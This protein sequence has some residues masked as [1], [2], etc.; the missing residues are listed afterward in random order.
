[1]L[2][3]FPNW[4]II[5]NSKKRVAESF[6]LC[7]IFNMSSNCISRSILKAILG[8]NSLLLRR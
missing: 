5:K 2:S 7:I 4:G 1:L 6:C 8:L 3:E